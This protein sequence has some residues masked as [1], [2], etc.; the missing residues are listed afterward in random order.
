MKLEDGS[1]YFDCN[2]TLPI[3]KEALKAF[4]ECEKIGFAN[5]SSPYF[6]GVE[7][8]EILEKA[9]ENILKKIKFKGNLLFASSATEVNNLVLWSAAENQ[10]IKKIIVSKIEHPSILELLP[11]VYKSGKEIV[12]IN[13]N[14]D[15]IV[16]INQLEKAVSSDS[17]VSILTAHNETGVIQPIKEITNICKSKEALF[18]TDAVQGFGKIELPFGESQPN[19][20]TISSHKIGGPKGVAALAFDEKVKIVPMLKGGGQEWGLRASTE[21]VP[22]VFSFSCAVDL[23]DIGKFSELKKMRDEMEEELSQKVPLTIYGKHSPRLPN[24]SFFS[25]KG[26]DGREIQ[27]IL[28]KQKIYVGTGSACHSSGKTL[29]KVL[30]EM[31]FGKENFPLR[32]SFSSLTIEKDKRHFVD[33]FCRLLS[34]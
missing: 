30:L 11:F 24:T 6:I 9:R 12:Q 27:K 18:H 26:K 23:I 5:P 34:V 19:A 16:D 7:A 28:D 4:L 14:K 21:S 13:V 20:L 1:F 8:R 3:R 31:G 33:V 2:A 17:F 15:G 10:K 25:I 32:I 22:L 29:P